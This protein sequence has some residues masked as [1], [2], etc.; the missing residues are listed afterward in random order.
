MTEAY[1]RNR[2]FNKNINC[3][4]FEG[5]TGK[6]PNIAKMEAFGNTCF[7]LVQ[8]P[9][10]LDNRSEKGVFIDYDRGSPSYLVYFPDTQNVKKV[11][12]VKFLKNPQLSRGDTGFTVLPSDQVY[13]KDKTE[14]K[15]K[16]KAQDSQTSQNVP[17]TEEKKEIQESDEYQMS[18]GKRNRTRPKYF[19]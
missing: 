7:A 5:M 12:E 10:K 2:C 19:R 1:I 8:S 15:E 18:S 3:T 6:K 4:P 17:E 11:R 9:K 14:T 16:E 13:D